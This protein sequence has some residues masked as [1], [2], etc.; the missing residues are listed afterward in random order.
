[1]LV[2]KLHLI[3]KHEFVRPVTTCCLL[4]HFNTL[5]MF[6]PNVEFYYSTVQNNDRFFSFV[7]TT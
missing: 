3:M 1:M 5:L 6:S 4:M 7:A 2:E